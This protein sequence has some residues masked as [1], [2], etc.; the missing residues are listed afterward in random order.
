VL[1]SQDRSL[2]GALVVVAAAFMVE[3][4]WEAVALEAPAGLVEAED[5]EALEDWVG[6]ALGVL[7]DW[8]AEA[9]VAE[10]V[11][12]VVARRVEWKQAA[13]VVWVVD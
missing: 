11:D 6:A 12:S 5:S 1:F 7:E 4:A 10:P 3:A 9:S 8:V 13:S 2:A